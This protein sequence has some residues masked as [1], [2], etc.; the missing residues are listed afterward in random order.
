MDILEEKRLERIQYVKEE[1]EKI[2]QDK[3]KDQFGYD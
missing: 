1:C 2:K 3:K